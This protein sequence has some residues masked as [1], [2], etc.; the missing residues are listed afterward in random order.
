M[1]STSTIASRSSTRKNNNAKEVEVVDMM[2][3]KKVDE[4]QSDEDQKLGPKQVVN[5]SNSTSATTSTT[6]STTTITTTTPTTSTTTTPTIFESLKRK[7]IQDF[8]VDRELGA[9]GTSLAM[10]DNATFEV[11]VDAYRGI[12]DKD[13]HQKDTTIFSQCIFQPKAKDRPKI[14]NA[15]NENNARMA[16]TSNNSTSSTNLQERWNRSGVRCPC[17]QNWYEDTLK[18]QDAIKAKNA[19]KA[20]RKNSKKSLRRNTETQTQK[21]TSQVIEIDGPGPVVQSGNEDGT[22]TKVP[23]EQHL[24]IRNDEKD[25]R[26]SCD[27]NPFCISSLGGIMDTYLKDVMGND[28]SSTRFRNSGYLNTIKNQNT[29]YERIESEIKE[30]YQ[31]NSDHTISCDWGPISDKIIAMPN[32]GNYLDMR[33]ATYVDT[34]RIMQH[35]TE[36]VFP[37]STEKMI[38][39]KL[40]IIRNW[41]QRLIFD[42]GEDQ[43]KDPSQFPF[44]TPA[45]V[46]NL[47][48]TCYLNCL[49]QCLAG[50]LPFSQGVFQMDANDKA[51]PQEMAMIITKLK[52]LIARMKYGPLAVAD[53]NEFSNSLLLEN[54]VMQDPNEFTRL[55]FDRMEESF[56]VITVA[57]VS[58]GASPEEN[59]T[60]PKPLE[61]GDSLYCSKSHTLISNPDDHHDSHSTSRSGSGSRSGSFV[62]RPNEHT[63]FKWQTKMLFDLLKS[64]RQKTD[65]HGFFSK[66][67]DPDL[68]ECED[69][70]D[71][72]N[73][74]DAMSFDTMQEMI[75]RA[76]SGETRGD[77]VITSLQ[78]F[79]SCLNQIIKCARNY[80][81]NEKSFIRKE[82]DLIEKRSDGIIMAM[83]LKWADHEKAVNREMQMQMQREAASVAEEALFAKKIGRHRKNSDDD[84]H[85]RDLKPKSAPRS[86]GIHKRQ[87]SRR[88]VDDVDDDSKGPPINLIPSLFSGKLEYRTT[89]MK[90]NKTSSRAE[91]FMDLNLPIHSGGMVSSTKSASVLTLDTLL[92]EYFE[93]EKMIDGN[94]YHCSHCDEN[95]EAERRTLIVSYPPVLNVQLGRYVY[96]T[97]TW[98]KRKVRNKILLPLCLYLKMKSGDTAKY[99]L[100][101]TQNHK[102][103]SA[104]EGHYIAEVMDW[105]TGLWF[106]YDDDK[107]T[108]LQKPASSYNLTTDNPGSRG[109]GTE[110]AY[111]VFYVEEA[112]LQ[113][114]TRIHIE[115][116][117]T[118]STE[119]V[120]QMVSEERL[121]SFEVQKEME[122]LRRRELQ[123]LSCRQLAISKFFLGPSAD[124][125]KVWVEG[126]ILKRFLSCTDTMDDLFG[127]KD[128]PILKH[129]DLLCEHK[130]GLHP[131]VARTGKLLDVHQFHI[132]VA[133]LQCERKLFVNSREEVPAV[134]ICDLTF[135]PE[136]NI[137]CEICSERYQVE[138]EEKL[139][140]FRSLVQIYSSLDPS[141]SVE[142]RACDEEMFALSK[143]FATSLRKFISN[144]M[145]VTKENFGCV[146]SEKSLVPFAGIDDFEISDL[147]PDSV[148]SDDIK[149]K[150]S[151]DPQV[152]SIITCVH[153]SCNIINNKRSVRHVSAST[154]R[155]IQKIFP[156]A[157]SHPVVLSSSGEPQNCTKCSRQKENRK[158]LLDSFVLWADI[159]DN[160]S[161]STPV[162]LSDKQRFRLVHTQTFEAWKSAIKTV[163]KK[164]SKR[165]LGTAEIVKLKTQIHELFRSSR[166][167]ET[168]ESSLHIQTLTCCKHSR[169]LLSVNSVRQIYEIGSV[170]GGDDCSDFISKFSVDGPITFLTDK[171]FEFYAG[172][173]DRLNDII[174]ADE[175]KH[176]L[177]S[178]IKGSSPEIEVTIDSKDNE[179]D[180]YLETISVST[181]LAI[182]GAN[183]RFLRP[184]CNDK[185]CITNYHDLNIKRTSPQVMVAEKKGGKDIQDID[186]NSQMPQYFYQVHEFDGSFEPIT[187]Q[188]SLDKRQSQ[189]AKSEERT[190]LRRSNRKKNHEPG[191]NQFSFECNRNV[192]LAQLRLQVYQQSKNR[193][194]STH[195]LSIYNFNDEK[196]ESSL[197]EL[198]TD[199]DNDAMDEIFTSLPQL[200]TDDTVDVIHLVLN[201]RD[202]LSTEKSMEAKK[203]C[204]E[205]LFSTLFQIATSPKAFTTSEGKKG[206]RKRSVER[207]F[208]GTFLQSSSKHPGTQAI[209]RNKKKCKVI[210]LTC[211][212]RL[213]SVSKNQGKEVCCIDRAPQNPELLTSSRISIDTM[214]STSNSND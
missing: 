12:C 158:D 198:L 200:I 72:V 87:S 11:G 75:E 88:S 59:E 157:I 76:G 16:S 208:A 79:K 190:H 51:I 189:G 177:L 67:I 102:G 64:V 143:S 85:E 37:E 155:H 14:L 120:I 31:S 39:A 126:S 140:R 131:R 74:N 52:E 36:T 146:T 134:E 44:C 147:S 206:S 148:V 95:C 86:R 91:R 122:V 194:I 97:K 110:E 133:L 15:Q 35:L 149:K 175:K 21:I 20:K 176:H 26:C 214:Y 210:D 105:T 156:E 63:R 129:K 6:T 183:L 181:I 144:L 209:T 154:W 25:F 135:S 195:L 56:R 80:Y 17:F 47:G 57:S 211:D 164:T 152:N 197:H 61:I 213:I 205:S 136:N 8:R 112:F 113:C 93:P 41:H 68:D 169:A 42:D 123:Q 23:V 187:S 172:S 145:K 192:N 84:E 207:G 199:R 115:S 108:L 111:N 30:L 202:D 127:Q 43:R 118:S 153:G 119:R 163:E 168:I 29:R 50:N 165:G 3:A 141:S 116:M 62:A 69:Y 27:F 66:P 137:F 82:A 178:S 71:V 89:C 191:P 151:I 162:S 81:S 139:D 167:E 33:R 19:K 98:R 160:I 24:A 53:A 196:K 173:L 103:N 124:E 65:Q 184:P 83:S 101:A 180:H 117:E 107:V 204:D 4:R 40:N 28:N 185:N 182:D 128:F 90:C 125:R 55:L 130:R 48:N 5:N 54:D 99:M 96:D 179:G 174:S 161:N 121:Q 188:E 7:H 13:T 201:V 73:I 193:S 159:A 132:Y 60:L 92:D 203:E 150:N 104:H 78:E 58:E 106:Q 9:L 46:G 10:I 18:K 32:E 2:T 171:D 34:K 70:Y 22:S 166:E 142:H 114:K 94:K 212:D 170:N 38:I 138:V 100:C 77:G 1:R 109:G 45:G 49:L 186:V